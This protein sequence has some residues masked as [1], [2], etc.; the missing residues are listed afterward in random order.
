VQLYTGM[1]YRGPGIANEITRGLSAA[2]DRKGSA[3]LAD[4]KGAKTKEWAAKAIPA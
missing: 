4:L 2:L 1:I 3:T